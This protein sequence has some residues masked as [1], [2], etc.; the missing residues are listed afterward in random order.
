[1][2][3]GG[4]ARRINALDGVRGI[5]A[6]VVVLSHFL[7]ST[8]IP[9]APWWKVVKGGWLGVD[10]FFVLSGFLIT[11]VLLDTRDGPH[12]LRSF[13]VR[14][15]LRIFPL[16]YASVLL[17]WIV[18]VFVEHAGGRL[19]GYDAIGWSFAYANNI[20]IALKKTW[21]YQSDW[22]GL[23]HFWSLAVEEQFYL[24]WPFV[25]L[26]P[27]R[28][29]LATTALI[30]VMGPWTRAYVD[31]LF[32]P[33]SLASY[34][35]TPCR[36]DA[37]A[38]G[39]LLAVIRRLPAPA[40]GPR[41]KRVTIGIAA[42]C[43]GVGVW[44]LADAGARMHDLWI[45]MLV[46][47]GLFVLV[48]YRDAIARLMAVFCGLMVVR[49][50]AYGGTQDQG[51]F[52]S[53]LFMSFVC[54]SLRDGPR[55]WVRR[56]CEWPILRHLG[57]YSY[58]LYVFHHM[59]KPIWMWAFGDRLFRSALNPWLAQAA[60][61]AAASAGTY[62]LARLSWAVL[63]KPCLDLKDKWALA[64]QRPLAVAAPAGAAL[65]LE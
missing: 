27:R 25:I 19:S 57:K 40:A 4:Q 12:Y 6:A 35:L 52:T 59:M 42:A 38:A 60:Y 15:V 41:V 55:A 44:A 30:V 33:Y 8:A 23:S 50:L 36:M 3:E 62:A 14:R 21:Q 24:V 7:V 54:L 48:P 63:E 56:L 53:L 61:V 26:L 29:V 18:I 10:L 11:G 1:V 13:Y 5:A 34:V 45:D 22:L 20:A 43:C 49:I 9:D 37:L 39:A 65:R 2:K 46:L 51:T 64:R 16:Y 28:A 58:A 32:G 17:V 47:A 31:S